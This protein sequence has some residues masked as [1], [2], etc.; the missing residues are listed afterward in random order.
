MLVGGEICQNV[1]HFHITA[2]QVIFVGCCTIYILTC[3]S[4]SMIG[5][6]FVLVGTRH[7]KNFNV[8]LTLGQ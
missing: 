6:N 7:S 8:N 5:L 3:I 2:P 1:L 4:D